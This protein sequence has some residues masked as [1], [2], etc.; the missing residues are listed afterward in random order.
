MLARPHLRALHGWVS[1]LRTLGRYD[2][3]IA[4]CQEL[5]ALDRDDHQ[6]DR[7]LLLVLL[8]QERRDQEAADLLRTVESTSRFDDEFWPWLDVLAQFRLHGDAPP[9]VA[10]LA[11]ARRINRYVADYLL[12]D[13]ARENHS[14]DRIAPGRRGDAQV[15]ALTMHEHWAQTEGALAWLKSSPKASRVGPARQVGGATRPSRRR[16][17]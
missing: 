14:P 5:L 15:A 8:L 11:R 2:E 7:E 9:A 12:D 17:R 1:V 16:T 10:A 13:R 4:R 6:H 3:A